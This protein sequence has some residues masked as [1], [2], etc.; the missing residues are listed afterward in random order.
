M[1]ALTPLFDVAPMVLHPDGIARSM[2]WDGNDGGSPAW[3]RV[4]DTVSAAK[5]RCKLPPRLRADWP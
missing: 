5:A 2:R 4:L 1:G 3:A